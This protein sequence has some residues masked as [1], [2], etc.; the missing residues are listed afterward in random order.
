MFWIEP[1]LPVVRGTPRGARATDFRTGQRADTVANPPVC[2]TEDPSNR[3]FAE[4]EMADLSIHSAQRMTVAIGLVPKVTIALTY[5]L[6]CCS[7]NSCLVAMSLR[8]MEL[9]LFVRT[10]KKASIAFCVTDITWCSVTSG[11]DFGSE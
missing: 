2:A 3:S 4:I 6:G 8:F 1:S 7:W 11:Y 10:A 9:R 5:L